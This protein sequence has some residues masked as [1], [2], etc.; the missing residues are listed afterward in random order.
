MA[1]QLWRVKKP[2]A[3]SSASLKGTEVHTPF[4]GARRATWPL[5]WVSFHSKCWRGDDCRFAHTSPDNASD[6]G[7]SDEAPPRRKRK[8][9]RAEGQRSREIH[10]RVA[11]AFE[12]TKKAEQALAA[13]KAAE[14]RVVKQHKAKKKRSVRFTKDNRT[15]PASSSEESE[16]DYES[17]TSESLPDAKRQGGQ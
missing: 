13:A 6:S 5:N 10:A 11:K 12:T 16:L 15:P 2:P 4:V 8:T 9:P 14:R 3:K 17:S 7:T 1:C